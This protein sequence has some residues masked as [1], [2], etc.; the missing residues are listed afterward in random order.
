MVIAAI[1]KVIRYIALLYC[2]F[3]ATH[4]ILVFAVLLIIYRNERNLLLIYEIRT[5]ANNEYPS[6]VLAVLLKT[7]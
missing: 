6:Y 1:Q 7:T 2:D 3:Y 4:D 5:I